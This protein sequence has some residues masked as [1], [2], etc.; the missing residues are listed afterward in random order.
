[1][2]ITILGKNIYKARRDKGLSSDT[3]SELCDITPSYLRQIEAGSKTPSL[4]LFV[5]LCNKLQVSPDYLMHGVV[6]S[7][8]DQSQR[9]LADLFDKAT[10]SQLQL[11]KVM[12]KAAV[13]VC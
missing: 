1:M 8:V 13:E 6:S 9:E 3:L 4:Q 10:P 2:D 12:L 11:I 5:K 7:A